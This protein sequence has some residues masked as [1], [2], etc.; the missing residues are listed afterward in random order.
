MTVSPPS[1]T[2]REV[3]LSDAPHTHALMLRTLAEPGVHLIS[4]PDEFTFTIEDERRF[5]YEHLMTA[6]SCW[7]VAEA[8]LGMGQVALV[9]MVSCRGHARAAAAHGT[10][11]G[12]TV[13]AGWRD[14]GIGGR[15]LGA[16]A[17]WARA[18]PLIKRV[19]L[20]VMATNARA[21]HLYQKY[22]YVVEGVQRGMYYK[23]TSDVK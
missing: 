5:I 20:N 4:A 10:K 15:L 9:G 6:N 14:R 1:I 16:A 23:D 21:I 2:I 17:D 11:L 13:A 22:G 7:F 3:R 8:H 18:N 12:I 19:E